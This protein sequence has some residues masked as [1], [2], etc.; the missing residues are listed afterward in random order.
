MDFTYYC[1]EKVYERFGVDCVVYINYIHVCM[2]LE[3]LIFWA[4]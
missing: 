2:Y 4:V 1:S 3:A